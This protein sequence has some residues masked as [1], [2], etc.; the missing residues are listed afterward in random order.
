MKAELTTNVYERVPVLPH[1]SHV[2]VQIFHT[3]ETSVQAH[4]P[5]AAFAVEP[6]GQEAHYVTATIPELQTHTFKV[7]LHVADND[8]HVK[9][10]AAKVVC[11]LAASQLAIVSQVEVPL[12]HKHEFY[13]HVAAVV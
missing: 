2:L 9:H 8:E 5:V 13:L 7:E 3:Y 10:S 11:I 12:Y 6:V 1:V 4:K